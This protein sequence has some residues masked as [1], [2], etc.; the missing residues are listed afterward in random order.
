MWLTKLQQKG[1]EI[2]IEGDCLSLTAL[3]DF[4]GNLEA[5]R[6]FA[7][8]VEII[9][10]EVVAA[11]ENLPEVIHF[12]I[13]G[14]FQM[15]GTDRPARPEGAKENAGPAGAVTGGKIG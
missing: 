15:S 8:P 7:R 14:T 5:S 13:K 9:N 10:S 4:V 3:S 1:M 6:Y 11:R 12:S 2:T